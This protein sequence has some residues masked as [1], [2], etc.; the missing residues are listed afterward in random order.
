MGETAGIGA[1]AAPFGQFLPA[2]AL[3]ASRR[4]LPGKARLGI[5]GRDIG[6][7][8]A[9]VFLQPHAAA[10]RHFRD[11]VEREDHHL[12]VGA[13]HGDGVARHRRNRAS[14]VRH[15]DVQDLLALAGIADAVVFVDDKALPV[16]AGDQEFAAALVD[17]QGHDR[18]LL[19]HVDEHPDRLAMTA[20]TREL[21]DIE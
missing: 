12:V 18:G 2:Q 20:P 7:R 14:L 19:L 5:E 6:Q 10:A 21:R 8:S 11:L 17:E 15:F 13:D 16:V 9:G 1:V 3:V 4:I